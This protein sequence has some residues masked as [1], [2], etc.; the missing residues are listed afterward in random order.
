MTDL[1]D[2]QF[3]PEPT[4]TPGGSPRWQSTAIVVGG[5]ALLAAAILAVYLVRR[6]PAE[7]VPA[8]APPLAATAADGSVDATEEILDEADSDEVPPIDLPPLDGSDSLVRDLVAALSA[9]PTFV[10]WIATDDL[11][12]TFVVVAENMAEGQTPARHLGNL[13]PREPFR[14]AGG[15]QRSVIDPR[16]YERYDLIADA[17]DSLDVAGTAQLFVQLAPLLDDAYRDLGHPDGEFRPVLALAV[18]EVLDAP[19]V[20][21]E[22]AVVSR[23]V[24]FEFVDPSL[25]ALTPV[26]R[27]ALRM[28][29][30]NLRLVQRKL[31]ELS[32]AL[33]LDVPAGG[34]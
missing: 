25:E 7:M 29:P 2:F 31:R 28:G 10:A 12:R 30:R 17:F 20:D 14:T 4:P 21:G 13:S 33:G 8:E 34:A 9:H 27:Q 32:E 23:S 19:I 22:I 1:G 3:D 15:R 18:R 5:V 6:G 11:I 26:Q 16:S 24:V